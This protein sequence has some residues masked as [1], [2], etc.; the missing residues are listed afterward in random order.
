MKVCQHNL[1]I[2][3]ELRQ[4]LPACPAGRDRFLGVG[5][6]HNLHKFPTARRHR[7]K[8]RIALG[9]YGESVADVLDIA[10]RERPSVRRDQHRA[11]MKS[12]VR[13]ISLCRRPYSLSNILV[14]SSL[15]ISYQISIT[16]HKTSVMDGRP[17]LPGMTRN[18]SPP[19]TAENLRGVIAA[20]KPCAQ[21]AARN[22][23]PVGV[24]PGGVFADAQSAATQSWSAV[25]ASLCRCQSIASSQHSPTLRAGA[26][27]TSFGWRA[28]ARLQPTDFISK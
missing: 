4:H 22:V 17:I 13:G 6:N 24:P 3:I 11:N 23:P 27:V 9:T 12:G 1:Q 19:E 20:R 21:A 16:H 5:R 2:R 15:H 7:G 8:H 14:L 26:R 10:P 25:D 18:L 28:S